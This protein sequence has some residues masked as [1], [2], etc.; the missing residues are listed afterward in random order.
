MSRRLTL[1]L[2][3]LTLAGKW[4]DLHAQ[5]APA[6]PVEWRFSTLLEHDPATV[7]AARIVS[8]AFQR[9]KLQVKI[10]Q[11]PGERALRSSN[12]GEV[13]GELY[14]RAGIEK[15][16]PNLLMVPVALMNYEIVVFS[17][18]PDLQVDNWE[19]L[20]GAVIGYVKGIKIIEANT[21][22][23]HIDPAPTLRQAF[24]K[25][26]LGRCDVV[27]A[28][29]ISGL[30]ALKAMELRASEVSIARTALAKFPVYL[31]L[32][33]KHQAYLP[34]ILTSLQQLQEEKMMQT[35][36]NAVLSEFNR[37]SAEF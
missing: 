28:N 19:S 11:M 32:H 21:G 22:G 36:Q 37:H 34:Q 15:D 7:I 20:R 27:L 2:A 33:K 4:A 13:D 18:R 17:R 5:T 31:Y 3:I 1:K 29:R 9:L 30:A 25:L 24:A 16:Y 26:M 12:N 10:E 23:M 35:I 6:Q 8:L 14:R